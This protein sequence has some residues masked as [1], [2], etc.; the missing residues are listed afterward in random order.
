[1]L[2]HACLAFLLM[3]APAF[4]AVQCKPLDKS[5]F[6]EGTRFIGL[7]GGQTHFAQGAFSALPPVGAPGGDSAMLITAPDKKAGGAIAF[8]AGE[9]VCEV[10][11]V[12]PDF[13]AILM[14][15]GTGDLGVKGNDDL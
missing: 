1:M 7:T 12:G 9:L 10:M 13:I 8:T 6:P 14:R 4:A 15:V 11:A 2:K 5:K 3:S